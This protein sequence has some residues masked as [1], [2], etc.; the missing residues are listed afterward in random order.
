MSSN[1]EKQ[2]TAERI[3]MGISIAI[4]AAVIG[5]A[6]WSSFATGDSPPLIEV[7]V[8]MEDMRETNSGFYVPITITNN[9]GFTAQNAT[10]TGE[11]V[12]DE[13]EPET[14]E[15]TIDFLA[16]GESETAG[17]VFSTDPNEGELTVAPTSYLDP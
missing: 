7:D 1:P 3:T 12:T 13:P 5:L 11:L 10:V 9:G 15:V 2:S 4:L 8:H 17:L 6:S 16:G 14:A